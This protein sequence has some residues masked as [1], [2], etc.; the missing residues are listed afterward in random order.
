MV[1]VVVPVMASGDRS[2]SG[3]SNSLQYGL[4]G[5]LAQMGGPKLPPPVL[6]PVPPSLPPPPPSEPLPVPPSPPEPLEHALFEQLCPAGQLRPQAP[7]FELLCVVSMH[8]LLQ[9]PRPL[10]QQRLLSQVPVVHRMPQPPQL[11]VSDEVSEQTPPQHE[12]PLGQTLPHAPQLLGSAPVLTQAPLHAVPPF[13][14]GAQRP[15]VH[16]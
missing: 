5:S 10:P 9:L 7:Q 13:G 2:A 14:Q 12:S 1:V 8:M 4:Q 3:W 11:F 6:P 15:L 16:K